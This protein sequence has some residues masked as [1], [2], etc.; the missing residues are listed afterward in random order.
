LL[1]RVRAMVIEFHFTT[2]KPHDLARTLMT[3]SD[4]AFHVSV[5][6]YG[7]WVDLLNHPNGE[8][9]SNVEFDQNLLIC[10]WRTRK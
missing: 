8:P 4:S 10:A 7:P 5:G 3:L 9:N 2:S 1:D 6:S